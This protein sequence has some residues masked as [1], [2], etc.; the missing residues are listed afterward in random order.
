MGQHT[1]YNVLEPLWRSQ[2][3]TA[4]L[5]VFDALYLRARRDGVYGDQRGSATRFRV[6]G[7]RRSTSR[8]FI[9]RLPI[10]AYDREWLDS[11]PYPEETVQPGPPTG[12]VHDP[13]TIR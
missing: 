9:P 11:Q 2:D 10:D 4:W 7:M 13:K 3:V 1:R 8:K 5:R 12:Y 6:D